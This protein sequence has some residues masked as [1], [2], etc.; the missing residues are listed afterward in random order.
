MSIDMVVRQ[1]FTVRG[2]D[3]HSRA[4]TVMDQLVELS[5]AEGSGVLD[6]AVDVDTIEGC[7][8]I[9]VT[10]RAEDEGAAINHAIT[11]MRTAIHAAGDG[12]SGWPT[13]QALRDLVASVGCKLKVERVAPVCA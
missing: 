7:V 1:A 8:W 12:T 3:A 6:S 2:P 11:A 10:V 5:E 13:G 9:E 4:D